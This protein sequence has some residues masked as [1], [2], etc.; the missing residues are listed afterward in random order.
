MGCPLTTRFF[1]LFSQSLPA[2]KVL[3]IKLRGLERKL[4]R[5]AHKTSLEHERQSVVQIDGLQLGCTRSRKCFRVGPVT[6]HAIVQTG[7]AR[8]EPFRLGVIFAADQPHELV[9]EVAMKPRWTKRM[10][11]DHPTRRK[12]YEVDVGGSGDFRR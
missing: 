2:L 1:E 7:A 4:R 3:M 12:D 11:G 5:L 10:L 8:H 9:H 6:R